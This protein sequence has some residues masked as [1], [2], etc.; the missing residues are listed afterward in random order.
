MSTRANTFNVGS[1]VVQVPGPIREKIQFG[2][3]WLVIYDNTNAVGEDIER[4]LRGYS[5]RGEFLWK[6]QSIPRM[7]G[8]TDGVPD[9]YM[10][11]AGKA[12]DKIKIVT[13]REARLLLDPRTGDLYRMDNVRIPPVK[14]AEELQEL[15]K[16][17]LF[18][19]D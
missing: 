7:P 19:K 18:P 3:M 17:G 8:F 5:S 16:K 12:H 6:A 13:F 9:F 1:L 2:D 10:A 11:F 14:F 15:A 4:N